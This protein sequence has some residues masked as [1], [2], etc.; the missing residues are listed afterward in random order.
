MPPQARET[1]VKTKKYDD[2]KLKHFCTVKET[3]NKLKRPP[4]EWEKIFANDIFNK[5]LISKN[6][7]RTHTNQHHKS[8]PI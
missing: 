7:Q 6:K 5:E 3:T 1:K 2:I 8:K 4:I